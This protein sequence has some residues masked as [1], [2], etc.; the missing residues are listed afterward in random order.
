MRKQFVHDK[1]TSQLLDKIEADP[2]FQEM[3]AKSDAEI[4]AGRLI[5]HTQVLRKFS[6]KSKAPKGKR[7]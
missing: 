4:A 5:S 6:S 1:R 7:K 3:M 2:S